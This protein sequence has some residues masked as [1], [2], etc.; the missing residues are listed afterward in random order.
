[1]ED[2]TYHAQYYEYLRRLVD[3]Y[4]N[5]GGFDEFY[6]RVRGQIDALVEELTRTPSTATTSTSRP[7]RRSTSS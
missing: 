2:E 4:I 5:G 6:N 3:E 1:M 7:W